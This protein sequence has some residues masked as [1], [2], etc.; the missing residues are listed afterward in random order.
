MDF[1]Q[2]EIQEAFG[3]SLSF[4]NHHGVV[5]P[6]GGVA[7]SL[8]PARGRLHNPILPLTLLLSRRLLKNS[9]YNRLSL[10]LLLHQL[11]LL[12][13]L[14]VELTCITSII[15]SALLLALSI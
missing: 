10:L 7:H 1:Y 6:F 13:E 15:C 8:R 9:E 14:L 5:V 11:A 3:V 4:Y 2:I 12:F